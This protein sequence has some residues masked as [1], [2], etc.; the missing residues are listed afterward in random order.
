MR[1]GPSQIDIN[2]TL[3]SPWA[4]YRKKMKNAT[5]KP[6]DDVLAAAFAAYRINGEYTK[7]FVY[8][9]YVTPDGDY[10][11]TIKRKS[12]K[13]M[14]HEHMTSKTL[15][16]ITAEDIANVAKAREHFKKYTLRSLDT[17][18]GLNDFEQSVYACITADTVSSTEFGIVA[19]IPALMEREIKDKEIK[20]I[21]KNDYS[22]S[23]HQ[24]NLQEKITRTLTILNKRYL[25]NYDRFVYS[26]GD[27]ANLY[28]F[29]H[30]SGVLNID[31]EY[32]IEGKVKAHGTAFKRKENETVLNYVKYRSI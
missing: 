32:E 2:F 21:I 16:P 9:D 28:S 11:Q 3:P 29:W 8:E 24:G 31:A 5:T 19:Y 15:M 7:N 6:V 17:T 4:G 27:G 14:V 20:K 10:I 12:N 23:E 13:V 22:A 30:S 18:N 1:S 26:A 25:Q